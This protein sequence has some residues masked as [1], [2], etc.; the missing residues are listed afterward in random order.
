MYNLILVIYLLSEVDI[1][2][3]ALQNTQHIAGMNTIYKLMD[4]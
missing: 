1:D 4:D 3:K 2:K